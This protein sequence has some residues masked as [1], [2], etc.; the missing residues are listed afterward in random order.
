[1]KKLMITGGLLGFA[2]GV[3]FGLLQES[4]WPAV[5]WRAS[6][7]ALCAGILLRWWGRLW[8]RS[9]HMACR[10]RQAEKSGATPALT[11]PSKPA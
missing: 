10:E 7:A 11:L 5:L 9:V 3:V 2:I 6:V 4:Q 8:A 1:M